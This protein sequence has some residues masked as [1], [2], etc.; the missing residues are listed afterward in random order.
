MPSTNQPYMVAEASVHD[1]DRL[2]DQLP[3][4]SVFHTLP[5]FRVLKGVHG[6]KVRLAYAHDGAGRCAAVWP[7][8]VMRKG[9][10]RILGSPVPGW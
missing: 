2:L 8:F 10:L 9:M 7:V 5:W 4:H 6:A 1:W 3:W